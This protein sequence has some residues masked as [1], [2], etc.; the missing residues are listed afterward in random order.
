MGQPL[1]ED[2]VRLYGICRVLDGAGTISVRKTEPRE[3]YQQF[4][5]I[6]TYKDVT[7]EQQAKI[8]QQIT[9]GELQR[10]IEKSLCQLPQIQKADVIT[11]LE[12]PYS[13]MEFEMEV[14]LTFVADTGPTEKQVRSLVIT[15]CCDCVNTDVQIS[16]SLKER[17]FGIQSQK[18]TFKVIFR[19]VP[20]VDLQ[21]IESEIY[22]D[23]LMEYVEISFRKLPEVKTALVTT[24]FPPNPSNRSKP[25]SKSSGSEESQTGSG[26]SAVVASEPDTGTAHEEV[27]ID[28]NLGRYYDIVTLAVVLILL[29]LFAWF[30]KP[31]C[32]ARYGAPK[33][34]DPPAQKWDVENPPPRPV[35]DTVATAGPGTP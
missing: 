20:S 13:D 5:F 22:S 32:I 11:E 2:E 10:I 35:C 21:R 29:L 14:D 26:E 4:A 24:I 3:S 34:E 27:E 33:A 7:P 12:I 25:A 28:P 19:D 18:F 23:E 6:A 16:V 31:A 8:Q 17:S 15:E 1:S 30:T 9:S